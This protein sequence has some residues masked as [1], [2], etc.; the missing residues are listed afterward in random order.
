MIQL[1]IDGASV[2]NRAALHALLAEGLPLPDY[3]G[4]NLDA[5]YDCLTD[6]LPEPVEITLRDFGA[7]AAALGLYAHKFAAVLARAARENQNLRFRMD[8]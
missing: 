3:Y 4:R 5:L 8:I 7:L 1:V 2:E 6:P